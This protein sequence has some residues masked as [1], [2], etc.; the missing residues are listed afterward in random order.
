MEEEDVFFTAM[1]ICHL[2]ARLMENVTDN[3]LIIAPRQV[4]QLEAKLEVFLKEFKYREK[5]NPQSLR[6]EKET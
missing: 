6:V 4:G 5:W 2:V 1:D 3:T